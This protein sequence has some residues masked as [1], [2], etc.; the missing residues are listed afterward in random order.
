MSFLKNN[1]N[2]IKST[3][4]KN[5]SNALKCFQLKARNLFKCSSTE[6]G[7]YD[8]IQDFTESSEDFSSLNHPATSTMITM[9]QRSA[10]NTE[11][12]AYY[13][14]DRELLSEQTILNESDDAEVSRSVQHESLVYSSLF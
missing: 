12:S 5:N 14:S 11:R 2:L 10:N 13:A 1:F 3:K 7:N 9:H 8:Y 6:N 4:K